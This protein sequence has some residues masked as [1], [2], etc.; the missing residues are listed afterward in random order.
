MAK[1]IPESQI[2]VKKREEEDI[3]KSILLKKKDLEEL[4]SKTNKENIRIKGL[5][6][7]RLIA[8]T[9]FNKLKEESESLSN[10][11]RTLYN[12]IKDYNAKKK[13]LKDAKELL[14]HI[15]KE[16]GD[17]EIE[18]E[19]VQN[20]KKVFLNDIRISEL[21]YNKASEEFD[22]AIRSKKKVEKLL[23]GSLKQVESD[24]AKKIEIKKD[25][26]TEFSETKAS[27]EI[28]VRE[29]QLKVYELEDQTIMFEKKRDKIKDEVEKEKK[30]YLKYK[31]QLI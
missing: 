16:I 9:T 3:D 26:E 4:E 14:N 23:N 30:R 22:N 31:E 19:Y 1:K 18:L 17:K 6:E 11:V 28:D 15:N 21:S 8:T 12:D 10:D 13:E 27:I 25:I 29:L 7:Q 2:E 5:E 20:K 24:I